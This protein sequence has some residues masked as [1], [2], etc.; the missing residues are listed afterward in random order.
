MNT[1][2]VVKKM[3]STPAKPASQ[4]RR[5]AP[6]AAA[7]GLKGRPSWCFGQ[8]TGVRQASP[9]YTWQETTEAFPKERVW[10]FGKKTSQ[11]LQASRHIDISVPAS[12]VAN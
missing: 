3:V 2:K 5:S 9:A 4:S 6:P 12:L 7:T 10:C 11:V 1:I 8:T